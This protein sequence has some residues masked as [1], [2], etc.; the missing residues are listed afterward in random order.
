MGL[1]NKEANKD[2]GAFRFLREDISISVLALIIDTCL[3][4]CFLAE[5]NIRFTL[6]LSLAF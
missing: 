4:I 6:Y 2:K 1:F 5:F 3:I